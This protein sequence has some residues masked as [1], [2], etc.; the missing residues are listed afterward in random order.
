M[1]IKLIEI[2]NNIINNNDKKEDTDLYLQFLNEN[3]EENKEGHIHC[4]TLYDSFKYW[5]KT[6]NPNTKT[7]SNKEFI[8]N[9]KKHKD[10]N[11]IKIEGLT[12]LG[13][14]NLK[15]NN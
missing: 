15:L 10:I 11:K 6:N 4:S 14:R 2:Q 1:R 12:Q 9:L 13:I 7:P 5:F 3:T 8:N